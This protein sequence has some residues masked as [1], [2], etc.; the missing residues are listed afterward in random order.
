M[1]FYDKNKPLISGVIRIENHTIEFVREIKFHGL[2]FQDNLTWNEHINYIC[3]KTAK[4]FGIIN[5][6]YCF[7]PLKILHKLFFS[8]IVSHFNYGLLVWGQTTKSNK[9]RINNLIKK[10][11]K[12]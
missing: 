5:N 3:N 10:F 8:F 7:L 12:Y 9:L 4:S 6:I 2:I 11:K 1:K